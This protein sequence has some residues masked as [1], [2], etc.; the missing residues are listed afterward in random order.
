MVMFW[1]YSIKPLTCLMQAI[2]RMTLVHLFTPSIELMPKWR[3]ALALTKRFE[4]SSKRRRHLS[5]H[6][7]RRPGPHKL[8]GYSTVG[9]SP[10]YINFA[11]RSATKAT[12]LTAAF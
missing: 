10:R 11:N 7:L 4:F 8:E 2:A 12:L 3:G 5:N 9:T 6:A 1:R